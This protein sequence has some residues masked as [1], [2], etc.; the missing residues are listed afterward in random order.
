G[1][2]SSRNGARPALCISSSG[3][4]SAP[5]AVVRD[6]RRHDG[7]QRDL[8]PLGL[9]LDLVERVVANAGADGERS[10]VRPNPTVGTHKITMVSFVGSALG[11]RSGAMPDQRSPPMA[12]G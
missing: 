6:E 8:A 12:R 5:R 9:E 2:L 1:R 10:A 3:H 11:S 4:G 7:A